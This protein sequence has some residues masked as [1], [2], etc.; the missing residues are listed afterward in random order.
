[1]PSPVELIQLKIQYQRKVGTLRASK[2][3]DDGATPPAPGSTSSASTFLSVTGS[4]LREPQVETSAAGGTG[5]R[6][7]REPL[8]GRV[9]SDRFQVA[10]SGPV[11][12]RAAPTPGQDPLRT[13]GC[14]SRTQ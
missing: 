11:G 7:A 12:E 1:M 8:T 6:V 3:I 13:R 9:R 4:R 5:E 14:D 2:R 10:G